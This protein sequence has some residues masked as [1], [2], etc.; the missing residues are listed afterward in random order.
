MTRKDS[1][2]TWAIGPIFMI[3]LLWL[4]VYTMGLGERCPQ[5][6]RS[7]VEKGPEPLTAT[8]P[9]GRVLIITDWKY[10]TECGS[11]FASQDELIEMQDLTQ[12]GEDE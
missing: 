1:I 3:L 12:G 2:A 5:C 7:A 8:L 6:E 9:D 11:I 10:C 4:M